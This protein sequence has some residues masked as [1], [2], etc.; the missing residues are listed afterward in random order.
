MT[1]LVA[2]SESKF[3][4]K[5]CSGGCDGCLNL[6]NQDN[7]GLGDLIESLETLYQEQGYAD[8]ISRYAKF[9]T[10]YLHKYPQS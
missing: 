1:A 8:I 5:I 10:K 7:G 6:D 2:F 9:H 4:D 3:D